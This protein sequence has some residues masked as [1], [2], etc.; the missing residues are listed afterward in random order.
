MKCTDILKYEHQI[1]LHVLD[2]AQ[3]ESARIRERQRFDAPLV[4]QL[5]EFFRVFVDQCHHAKEER[6]LFPRL[7]DLGLPLDSGPIAVM[8][9][10]HDEG[11]GL[12]QGIAE[13]I[14]LAEAGNKEALDAVADALEDYVRL[15]RQHI[16]K[17]DNILF[18]IADARLSEQDQE[19]L[20]ESFEQVERDAV[21]EGVHER[22]HRFA[23]E[24][25]HRPKEPGLA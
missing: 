15:L 12:I 23:H 13:S 16:D 20:L 14:G 17:E 11:R 2:A 1:V 4:R 19:D 18:Y 22:F 24:L 9:A 10:E 7:I 5:V 25:Q 21:G 6:R 8:L 3:E